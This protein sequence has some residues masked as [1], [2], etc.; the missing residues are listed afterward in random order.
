MEIGN[1]EDLWGKGL[2]EPLVAIENIVI[3]KDNISLLS[4]DRTPTLKFEL[5][6]GISFIKFGS[7]KDE[8]EEL[9]KHEKIVINVVGKC[10]TNLYGG[11]ANA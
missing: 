9:K 7:N 4:P 3:T 5:P 6:N 1:L 2:D 11:H 8:Y 10:A